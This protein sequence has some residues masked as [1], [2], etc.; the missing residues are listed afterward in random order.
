[1]IRLLFG[2]GRA[3]RGLGRRAIPMTPY[4]AHAEAALPKAVYRAPF[5]GELE[6]DGRQG[7]PV[8]YETTCHSTVTLL[9]TYAA[10][11]EGA[12]DSDS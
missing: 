8:G 1:M 10:W 7:H 2:L 9:R 3:H 5:F 12:V 11:V 6:P 4:I